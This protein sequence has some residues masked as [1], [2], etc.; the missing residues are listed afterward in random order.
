MKD[1]SL[2]MPIVYAEINAATFDSPFG[3]FC[4]KHGNNFFDFVNGTHY[5]TQQ[6]KA[7]TV[8]EDAVWHQTAG[9]TIASD[10]I[11]AYRTHNAHLCK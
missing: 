6:I 9:N 10:A 2:S 3:C 7:F 1:L 11:L 4:I 8:V 5:P